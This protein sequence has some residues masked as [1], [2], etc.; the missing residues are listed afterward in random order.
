V[1]LPKPGGQG[2]GQIADAPE[3]TI[4][5]IPTPSRI[6]ELIQ[7]SFPL[8][9]VPSI[10]EIRLH[11]AGPQ[12]GLWRFAE[13]D[14]AFNSPYWAYHWGG[15]LALARYILD[16]PEIIA[17]RR[18]IDLGA[19]SGLV[20]IAAALS[21]AAHITAADIDRYAIVAIRLNAIANNVTVATLHED[22]TIQ[23]PPEA[24]VILVGDLFYDEALARRITAFL[25]RCLAANITILVGDPWR[26]HLPRNRL[27]LLAEYPGHD[28][29]TGNAAEPKTNAVFAFK[30]A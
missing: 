25:D 11:K 2:K 29:G 5:T 21:G 9:Q 8:T 27:D 12:S 10:P 16:H 22:L 24:D 18:V 20:A 3:A 15:G 23:P 1:T 28:F 19:G 4:S 6:A 13:A 17:G 26:A 14:R 30:L 7:A